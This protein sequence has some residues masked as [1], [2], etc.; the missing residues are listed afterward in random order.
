M[1]TAPRLFT[2]KVS[3]CILCYG[4]RTHDMDEDGIWDLFICSKSGEELTEDECRNGIPN[5]C[6]LDKIR[7]DT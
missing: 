7:K 3:C 1:E 2:Q 6:P 5:S 4:L